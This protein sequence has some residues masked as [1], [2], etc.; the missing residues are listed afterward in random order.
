[1]VRPG[2]LVPGLW[3]SEDVTRRIRVRP[4]LSLI[5]HVAQV[6]EVPAGRKVSYGCTYAQPARRP[7]WPRCRWATM[8]DTAGSPTAPPCWWLASARRCA[9]G[10]ASIRP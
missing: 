6:K 8:M 7:F 5:T 3:P 1:M 9:D 4:V 10:C 2:V